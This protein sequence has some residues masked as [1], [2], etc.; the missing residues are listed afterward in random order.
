MEAHEIIY[1]TKRPGEAADW[2]RIARRSRQLFESYSYP[3]RNKDNPH[4]SGNYS[5]LYDYVVFL[6]QRAAVNRDGAIRM[7]QLL[8]IEAQ[9]IFDGTVRDADVKPSGI[10]VLRNAVEVVGVTSEKELCEADWSELCA[11][12]DLLGQL[13]CGVQRLRAAVRV[14]KRRQELPRRREE[15]FIS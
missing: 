7:H 15:E 1:K 2:A 8:N 3:P 4:G 5:P 10:D 6:A 14:A 11:L 12:D 13:D 9:E